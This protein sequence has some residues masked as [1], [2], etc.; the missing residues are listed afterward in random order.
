M[1]TH[2]YAVL[3]GGFIYDVIR[4]FNTYPDLDK[5]GMYLYSAGCTFIAVTIGF[6]LDRFFPY[7]K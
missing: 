1:K 7:E 3:L 4:L 2:L 6:I 5:A